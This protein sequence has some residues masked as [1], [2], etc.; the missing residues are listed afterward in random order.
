M[1]KELLGKKTGLRRIQD[2]EESLKEKEDV[3]GE[4][5]DCRRRSFI[6][7]RAGS[8]WVRCGY[9]CGYLCI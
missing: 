7:K 9:T 4:Q 6:N 2:I 3:V 1:E 8:V 5:G